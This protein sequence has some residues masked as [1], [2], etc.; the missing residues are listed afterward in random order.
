MAHNIPTR[1]GGLA[2]NIKVRAL[3]AEMMAQ[4]PLGMGRVTDDAGTRDVTT[5]PEYTESWIDAHITESSQ[6]EW[7]EIAASEGF[8]MA[9]ER[10]TETFGAGVTIYQAGRSGGWMTV[11]GLGDPADWDGTQ[12]AEW[13]TFAGEI[14][15]IVAD[16]PYRW[17]W[18]MYTNAYERWAEGRAEAERYLTVTVK[19]ERAEVTGQ[20][21][22]AVQSFLGSRG[23]GETLTG[24]I[25]SLYEAVLDDRD[26]RAAQS[27]QPAVAGSGE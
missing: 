8:E 26:K 7:W 14:G 19:V 22:R 6:S 3:R 10:A 1:D 27:A 11:H 18:L 4:L 17:L 2:I 5:D 24:A 21:L 23:P 20:S 15:E 25:E 12:R 13:D 9:R 16:T